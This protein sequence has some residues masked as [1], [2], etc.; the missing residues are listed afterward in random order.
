MV[1]ATLADQENEGKRAM[2]SRIILAFWT[3][4][5]DSPARLI[6]FQFIASVV[7]ILLVDWHGTAI[8]ARRERSIQELEALFKLKDWRDTPSPRM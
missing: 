6:T 4:I 2:F 5:G 7:L 1:W 3:N 8:K